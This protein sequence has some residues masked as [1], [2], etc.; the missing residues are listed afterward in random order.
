MDFY[1]LAH[2][3]LYCPCVKALRTSEGVLCAKMMCT[4]ERH[5]A[6]EWVPNERLFAGGPGFEP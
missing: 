2:G 5:V 6:Y 4:P 3:Q 1:G